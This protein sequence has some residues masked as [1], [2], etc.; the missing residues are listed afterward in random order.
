MKGDSYEEDLLGHIEQL[1]LRKYILSKNYLEYGRTPD[2]LGE[3]LLFF[4]L[5]RFC[6]SSAV[7]RFS[8]GGAQESFTTR[9]GLIFTSSKIRFVFT[10]GL[11]D[12]NYGFIDGIA[13]EELKKNGSTLLY[14]L[15]L[16]TKSGSYRIVLPFQPVIAKRL[17]RLLRRYI[18]AKVK[19]LAYVQAGNKQDEPEQ[20][21]K[22]DITGEQ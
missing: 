2:P 5:G 15:L 18:C 1:S 21:Q 22:Y 8:D 11:R 9:C 12:L 20:E 16:S 6:G 14:N 7:L 10:D 17:S 19:A 4:P 3:E 13:V